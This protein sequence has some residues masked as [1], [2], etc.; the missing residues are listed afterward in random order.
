MIFASAGRQL[1]PPRWTGEALVA[2]F[3]NPRDAAETALFAADSLR[4]LDHFR[5][6]AHYGVVRL[7][8]DP[9]SASQFAAGAAAMIPARILLSTPDSAILISE[10]FAAVLCAGPAIGRPHVEHVGD[11]PEGE[12]NSIRLFSLKRQRTQTISSSSR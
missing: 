2:T 1:T 8:D 6:A 12:T 3:E 5:I 10:D 4:H 7:T 11:L 9:F